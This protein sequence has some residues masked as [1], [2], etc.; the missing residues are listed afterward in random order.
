ML[1]T[2]IFQLITHTIVDV[3]S[4]TRLSTGDIPGKSDFDI[5]NIAGVCILGMNQSPFGWRH[6]YPSLHLTPE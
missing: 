4:D 3:L 5:H 6:R 1:T 2:V